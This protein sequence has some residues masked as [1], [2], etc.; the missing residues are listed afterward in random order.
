MCCVKQINNHKNNKY[1]AFNIENAVTD[2]LF[3]G[4]KSSDL[5]DAW[6]RDFRDLFAQLHFV[7]PVPVVTANRTQLVNAPERRLIVGRDQFGAYAPDVDHYTLLLKT[8][9]D[10]LVKIITHHNNH[11]QKTNFIKN[12]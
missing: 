6:R 11:I 4:P 9:D 5:L 10:V 8:G 7:N 12:L 2:E 1:S 3:V